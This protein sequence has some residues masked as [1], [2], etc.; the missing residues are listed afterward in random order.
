MHRDK[1]YCHDN[2]SIDKLIYMISILMT[3]NFGYYLQL[4]F[5][6]SAYKQ[7]YAVILGSSQSTG[8]ILRKA[9]AFLN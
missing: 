6:S 1:I 9:L 4:H 5:A 2:L 3:L 8:Q 7:F